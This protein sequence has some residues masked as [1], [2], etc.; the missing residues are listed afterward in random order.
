MIRYSSILILSFFT[1]I[2]LLT[3]VNHAQKISTI[4]LND[5]WHF[6]PA[7][8]LLVPPKKD[9]LGQN[10]Q[11]A[12]YKT[13]L[14]NT[15]LNALFENGAIE[16]PFYGINEKRL[17]WLEKKDWIFEKTFD[18]DPSV[19]NNEKIDLILRGLDTYA[20]VSVND[21]FVL[22]ADNMFRTWQADIKKALKPQGNVL[23]IYF[24]SPVTIEKKK[25]ADAP[26]DYPDVY[27]TTRV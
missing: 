20:E 26:V 19:L 10:I 24:T 2:L 9:D 5:H 4:S 21:V 11:S 23:K 13:Q 27:N 15:A 14:P 8:A 6:M 17:Q 12:G 16:D 7:A 18:V 3:K 22:K 25:A 1:F